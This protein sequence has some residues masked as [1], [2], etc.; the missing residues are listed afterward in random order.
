M[1]CF[2]QILPLYFNWGVYGTKNWKINIIKYFDSFQMIKNNGKSNFIF[3]YRIIVRIVWEYLDY[4]VNERK[5]IRK[6][7]QKY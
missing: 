6:K 1:R 2:T 4:I 3:Y 7:N 5:N